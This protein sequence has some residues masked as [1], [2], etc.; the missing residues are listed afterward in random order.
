MIAAGGDRER[1][2]R[3]PQP[4][5]V[6]HG[7]P[8]QSCR[9]RAATPELHPLI[10]RPGVTEVDEAELLAVA[11]DAAHAAAGEL[12]A[13]YG[14]TARGVSTKSSPTDLV[15]DADI[16]AEAAIRDVLASRRPDDAILGEEGG[17]SGEGELLWLV[18]PLD[19]TINYLYG[20]PAF[21]VSVACERVG[22][23][24]AGV[25]Y[26]P[27]REECF[28]ATRSGEATLNGSVLDGPTGAQ[29]STAMIATGFGYEA[30]VR[31]RQAEV[32]E[33][34]L[35]R[36]RDIRRVGAAALDLAWTAC[37]RFDAYYER[38]VKRW[39]VAAGSLICRRVGLA[40]RELPE[41]GEEAWGL[42]VAP[43]GLMDELVGLVAG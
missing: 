24:L 22:E 10:E 6:T 28:S 19:G 15:S 8:S 26:D 3:S 32:L 27:V 29:L 38:G 30:P 41:R 39:D 23:G 9:L 40:V 37:G 43:N 34:V 1:Q 7:A 25:V 14:R 21:C 12:M 4:Q 35:P 13:R 2:F 17:A 36:V 18:D 42:A 33:R 16:A 11:I 20:I 31:A 5:P